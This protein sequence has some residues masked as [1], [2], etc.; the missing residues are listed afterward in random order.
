MSQI[1]IPGVQH[2][3]DPCNPMSQAFDRA[4][5]RSFGLVAFALNRHLIHHMLRSV[6]ELD[7]DFESLV[8]WG[9]LSHLNFAHLVPLGSVPTDVLNE[10]GRY[11]GPDDQLR[12]MRLRDLEQI[13]RLP[14]ETV[15]RKLKRLEVQGYVTHTRG[16]WVF[17]RD[18]LE[19]ALREF[20]RESLRRI[21][22]LNQELRRLLAAAHAEAARS[23]GK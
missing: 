6:R 5:D 16:G 23:E 9:L 12:P 10:V 8:I 14:R 3:D 20:N 19:P 21:M 1:G 15:R 7:V 17:K 13:S 18:K 22:M 11:D 2:V 4:F